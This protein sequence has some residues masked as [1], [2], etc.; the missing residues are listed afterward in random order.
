M[1]IWIFTTKEVLEYVKL[2]EDE[3]LKRAAP[4]KAKKDDIILIYRGQ[5][6]SNIKFIYKARADAYKDTNFRDDW[7]IAIDLVDKIELEKP[8][9]FS[10]MKNDP[11]LSNW[12]II[13]KNFMGSFFEMPSK[14]WDRLKTLII[15]RNPE[16]EDEI[17]NLVPEKSN[18]K[19]TVDQKWTFA[20]NK[21]FY[22]DLK[23]EE[24]IVWNSA[25]EVKKDNLIMIYTGAPYSSIGFILTSLTD[26]FE[27]QDIR[28]H[29]NRPAINVKKLL[30]INSPITLQEL[31]DNPILSQW[32]A[33]RMGFRGSHFKMS[34]DEFSEL[35]GLI[36][37][38]NPE[39]RNK[40]ESSSKSFN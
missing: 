11:I 40:I 16:L 4:L 3:E 30:E 1:K 34:D 8:V 37:E 6:Y 15:D 28:K 17:I 7:D 24:E 35:I 12:N 9:E 19:N 2:D 23:D 22:F 26:P 39:K 38:K 20:I 32:G 33:V 10:D 36:V 31:R 21:D 25:K 5:P 27:D 18:K 29:W 13:R 14:E